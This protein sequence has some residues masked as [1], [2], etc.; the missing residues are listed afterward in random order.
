MQ[1]VKVSFAGKPDNYAKIDNYVSRSAQ[2]KKA[3]F[4]WLKNE[5]VTDVFNFR[6]MTVSGLDFDEKIEVEKRGMKYHNIPTITREPNEKQIDT[7][8]KEID[9]VKAKNGKAHIH[10]KEKSRASLSFRTHPRTC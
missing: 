10:C 3:D 5:G 4:D 2:P 6:T 9:D 7:F 8:L 1:V